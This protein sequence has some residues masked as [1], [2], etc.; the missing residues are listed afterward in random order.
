MITAQTV[1]GNY[2]KGSVRETTAQAGG[3]VWFAA[4]VDGIWRL[5]ADG[6]GVIVCDELVSYPNF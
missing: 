4:K 1:E 6:N 3:G 5:V 2:A